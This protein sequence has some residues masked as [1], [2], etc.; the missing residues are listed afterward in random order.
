M[1]SPPRS[2]S[3]ARPPAG[4]THRIEEPEELR[5]IASPPRQ[6]LVAA[7]EALG[8]ASARELAARLGR[9]PQSL[10]F[11][12]EKLVA[13]GLVEVAG[14]RPV[15]RRVEKLY[16]PVAARLRVA[17]DLGDPAYRDAL[18]E[19]CRSVSR[20]ARRDYCRALEHEETRL[21]GPGRNLSMQHYH[22]HLQPNDRRR[23]V[24]MIEELTEFVL[25]KND[26]ERGELYSYTALF[27]PAY[28]KSPEESR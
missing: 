16:R 3:V 20:A 8:V 22:V 1:T 26:P 19:T 21:E 12:L 28:K 15:G 2:K 13:A 17:G 10:Y 24:R 6:R 5:A 23:L 11:H 9:S 25:A 7:L 27:A 14:E 4:S 18:A